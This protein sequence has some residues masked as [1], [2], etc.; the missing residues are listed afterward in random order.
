[1][2]EVFDQG[3]ADLGPRGDLN[4]D[5]GDDQHDDA[6]CGADGDVLPGAGGTGAEHRDH[7]GAEQQNLGP[8]PDDVRGDHQP[9]GEEAEI[10]IDGAA[11]PF[12]GRTAVGV[13]HVQPAV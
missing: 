10:R 4:A 13:P 6:D 1:Q 12:E 11:D 9:A 3:H 7:R 8:G 5:H 2:D